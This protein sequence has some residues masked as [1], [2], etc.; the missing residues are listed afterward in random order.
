MCRPSRRINVIEIES[1]GAESTRARTS[2]DSGDSIAP[3]GKI[4]TPTPART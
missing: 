3:D 2:G 1:A 4:P